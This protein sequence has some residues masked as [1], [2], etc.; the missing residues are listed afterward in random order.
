MS[1]FYVTTP[2]YYVNDAPHIGHAYTTVVAD[3]LA[4]FHRMRGDEVYFLTGTDEHGQKIED[5]ARSRNLEPLQLADQVVQRYHAL[6]SRLGMTHDD[7]IRTTEE[8]HK[9]GVRKIYERIAARGDDIY[10]GRYEGWYCKVEEAFYPESQLREGRC[11]EGHPVQRLSEE[12]YFFR[13]S[14]YQQPLLDLYTKHPE[15]IFPETRR[16]EIV[17]FV[18]S[19]LKDLSVSRTSFR[20]G[21]PFP[22][23]PG[24]IFYVWFDAL[25]NYVTA[26]GFAR[27]GDLYRK[28]WPADVHLV[29]KDILRF[30]A[31]YWPAFLMA[32]GLPLPKRVVAHGWWLRDAGKMSKSRGNVV[33]PNSL[34][35]DFGVDAVRYF[36]MREMAFGQDASYSDEA[37]IDRSNADLA[38]DLGNLASRT[39]KLVETLCGGTIPDPGA[40][41]RR[42]G[43]LTEPA[44]AAFDGLVTGFE[45]FDF[46]GGLARVWD[47]VGA[48][49]RFLVENEPWKAASDPARKD[50][51]AAVLYQTAEALRIV[52]LLVAPV[53]PRAAENLW[54]QLGIPEN[55][56]EGDLRGFRWGELSPGRPVARG[57]GLFPRVDKQAYLARL[58]EPAPGRPGT[59][60]TAAPG[61]ESAVEQAGPPARGA[62]IGI[63]EFKRVELRV[64]KIVAAERVEG[65]KKLF[66]VRVDLGTET[67]QIVSGIA[68]KYTPEQL[69]G[70]S[71]VVVCNLKPAVIRGVESRGMLLAA[72]DPDGRATIVTFDEPVDPGAVVR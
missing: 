55:P 64:G 30:H 47:L 7:F 28:F 17:S 6:W 42:A 4:R 49:N 8:R 33:E 53:M 70:K 51:V 40:S 31:V 44:R 16:N 63:D 1:R 41:V 71:I 52:G 11:P 35:D 13:L 56:A 72:A 29:G 18:S 68:D 9:E 19:G 67:R 45:E 15:F 14:R 66:R 50:G 36:L 2:I 62:E 21:I 10:K 24:H 20:W 3:V 27:E 22:G 26:L 60:A 48:A 43:D 23:D 46:S 57:E 69:V 58:A 38:N 65:A 25:S 59:A 12:S 37:L 32:A 54:R 61:K 34:L 39:L 5:T